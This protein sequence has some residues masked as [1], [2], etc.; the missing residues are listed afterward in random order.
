MRG[1]LR[2]WINIVVGAALS[3]AVFIVYMFFSGGM[4]RAALEFAPACTLESRWE[5]L[6][7]NWESAL[8]LLPLALFIGAF[9]G[10]RIAQRK[11]KRRVK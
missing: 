11:K 9:G 7:L 8:F 2:F 3:G 6:R 10:M 1:T 5:A 4:C